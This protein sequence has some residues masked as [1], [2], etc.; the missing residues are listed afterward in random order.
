MTLGLALAAC[1][2][3]YWLTRLQGPLTLERRAFWL[4]S[5]CK[6][7]MAAMGVHSRVEGAAPARGL[8]VSNHLSYVDILIYGA[9]MP[10]FFISKAEVVSWPFFGWAARTGGALFLDRRRRSSANAVAQAMAERLE[11]AVPVVLFPEGTSTDG[12]Q[13]QHFHPRLFEP[14]IIAAAPVTAAAIRYVIEGAEERELCWYGDMP[15]LPHLWKVLGS[16]GFFAVVHFGGPQV[17]LNRRTATQSTHDQ[18]AAMRA[19]LPAQRDAESIDSQL[20]AH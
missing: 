4:Q 20:R 3:H 13:V 14:A 6:R 17:Y 18:V 5:A 19:G 2:L 16:R 8:V 10:C 12:A 1:I 11:L 15:F 9:I 7:V